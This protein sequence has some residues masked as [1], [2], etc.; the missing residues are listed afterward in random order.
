MGIFTNLSANRK[1]IE[2]LNSIEGELEH[3][4]KLRRELHALD[5]E[6]INL[7]GKVKTALGRIEK[8]AAIIESAQGPEEED[9]EAPD[10]IPSPELNL[11]PKQLAWQKQIQAER[12]RIS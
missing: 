4:P 8:R 9:A 10:G 12:R 11:T 5:L 6:F 3:L 1:I 7:F 2:R